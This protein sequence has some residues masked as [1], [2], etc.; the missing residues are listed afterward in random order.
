MIGI[1]AIVFPG[2]LPEAYSALA[3]EKGVAT[4]STA[5]PGSMDFKSCIRLALEQSPYFTES[6][7]EIEIRHL[8]E[9]DSRWS[10]IP[11]LFLETKYALSR[12][13]DTN[14]GE[15]DYSVLFSSGK[16]DPFKSYFSLKARKLIT[17]I[18]ILRHQAVISEG[19]H[20]LAKKFLEIDTLDR[21]M[22]C[23][24]KLVALNRQKLTFVQERHQVGAASL[25]EV[26]LAAQ[27][28]ELVQAERERIASSKASVRSGMYSF[29][30]LKP[31]HRLDLNLREARRQ[32][33]GEFD[34]A[35]A[36]QE[37]AFSY[38]H[39]LK[40]QEL[41]KQL[42]ELNIILAYTK[43]IPTLSMGVST[44]GLTDSKRENDYYVS[45]GASVPIWQ[46]FSRS[47]DISRQR[48]ILR[49]FET[50]AEVKEKQLGIQWQSTMR[51]L[52]NTEIDLKVAQSSE[53]LVRLK[54]RQSEIRYKSNTQPLSVLLNSRIAHL[55][56]Q[57][58]RHW[59][60]HDFYLSVLE[61]RHLSGDLFHSNVNVAPWGE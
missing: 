46:G 39:E 27:E 14:G 13:D 61:I 44:P 23:Q 30:G 7:V 32:V 48:K 24:E 20:D 28:L 52:R 22:A 59:K 45:V 58:K 4:D 37:Q 60:K 8:D 38:S 49:Q 19:I 1:M 35:S 25:L 33:L 40:I 9:S 42:Q 29:L 51:A 50:E 31:A 18:A 11:Y 36:S 21:I 3:E 6:A 5:T 57:K 16:Y 12:S 10:F 34:P 26:R 55:D 2:L 54:V 47:R 53:E 56:A 17:Q 41:K 15:R 43:Y